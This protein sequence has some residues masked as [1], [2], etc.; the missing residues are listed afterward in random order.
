MK[1]E[2]YIEGPPVGIPDNEHL[3]SYRV[4]IATLKREL[5]EKERL[6]NRLDGNMQV[7][8]KKER[9]STSRAYER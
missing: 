1:S 9:L 2:T 7:D 8:Y 3:R 5:A 4:L 6:I